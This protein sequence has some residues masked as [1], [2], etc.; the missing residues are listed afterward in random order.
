[1][2]RN[3]IRSALGAVQSKGARNPPPCLRSRWRHMSELRQRR[4]DALIFEDNDESGRTKA[5]DAAHALLG[6]AKTIRIV[7]LRD[8]PEKG[9]WAHGADARPPKSGNFAG[10]VFGP[11]LWASDSP[12]PASAP[13]ITLQWIDMSNWGREAIPERQ[14]IIRDRVPIKQG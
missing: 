5:L 1:L 2:R 13:A 11:P 7:R 8:L 4:R 14:W 9:D 10:V 6:T 3:P 12:P